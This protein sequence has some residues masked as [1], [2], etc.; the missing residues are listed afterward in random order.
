MQISGPSLPAAL[1]TE[2]GAGGAKGTRVPGFSCLKSPPLTP[3]SQKPFPEDV[4]CSPEGCSAR[5]RGGH[6]P[7]GGLQSVAE[8]SGP[9]SWDDSG[10]SDRRSPE[11]PCWI[12]LRWPPRS[13]LGQYAPLGLC[14]LPCVTS[15]S[16]CGCF[17]L[18][19]KAHSD[20]GLRSCYRVSS[21][22]DQRRRVAASLYGFVSCF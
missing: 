6:A 11:V 21:N 22:P 4:S 15:L 13:W 2:Q 5:V 19:L 3:T 1:R 7:L 18:R 20:P 8:G 12:K 14:P 10:A 17:L 9:L 16:P